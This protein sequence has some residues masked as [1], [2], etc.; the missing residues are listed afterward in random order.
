MRLR[1]MFNLADADRHVSSGLAVIKVLTIIACFI[2]F[3][4]SG[5]GGVGG[6]GRSKEASSLPNLRR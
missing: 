2:M 1:S 3:I 6:N 4:G 5:I